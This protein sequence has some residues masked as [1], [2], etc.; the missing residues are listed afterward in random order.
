MKLMHSL[1]QQISITHTNGP[2][3][4]P[5]CK[6]RKQHKK[7]AATTRKKKDNDK[8]GTSNWRL[9]DERGAKSPNS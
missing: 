3:F 9:Y 8:A 4:R 1:P 7:I 6:K 5:R 2:H